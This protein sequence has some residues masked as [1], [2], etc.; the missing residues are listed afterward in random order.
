MPARAGKNPTFNQETH[1]VMVAS[2]S[3]VLAAGATDVPR[4]DSTELV[5]KKI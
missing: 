2:L 3:F 4:G 5:R 1:T